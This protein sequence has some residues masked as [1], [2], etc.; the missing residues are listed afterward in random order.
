MSGVQTLLERMDAKLS[1]ALENAQSLNHFSSGALDASQL[2]VLQDL[3]AEIIS[4]IVG[5]DEKLV[6]Q[7]GEYLKKA[8]DSNSKKMQNKISSIKDLYQSFVN[9]LTV[10]K[11][12][13]RL[14]IQD[15]NKSRHSLTVLQGSY[16]NSESTLRK[17]K[18]RLDTK[19]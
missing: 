18:T 1:E 5:L 12:L 15:L 8:D 2:Q 3:Q 14:E 13:L 9:N 11:E 7:Q 17:K 4:E 19:R 16:G 6:E 10:R